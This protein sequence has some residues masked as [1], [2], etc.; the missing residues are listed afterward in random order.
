MRHHDDPADDIRHLDPID[1][2]R[3]AATW[4]DGDAKKALFQE[5]ITMP[6]DPATS[7]RL[8]APVPARTLRR[9]VAFAV[10]LAVAVA[11]LVVIQGTLFKGAPAYAVRPLPNGVIEIS[12]ATDLRDGNAIAAELREYGVDVAITTVPG[13]PSAVGELT[14]IAPGGGDY[15]PEG[16]SYAGP[17]GTPGVFTWLIDP[18]VFH[19][20][21]TLQITVAA[22]AG[23]PY[24]IAE[25]VFEPGEVLGGLQCALG[26]PVRAEDVASR[27]GD[28]G[29]TPMWFVISP[30]DDPWTTYS[31]QVEDVPNGEILS[32]YAVDDTTVRFTVVPDGVTLSPEFGPARLSDVPCTPEQAAA[33][34]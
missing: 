16:L 20:R 18:E 13:S 7:T 30:T 10:G 31:E 12:F 4:S 1:G 26:E 22:R 33:W 24:V 14:A 8:P 23:E 11:A 27:L 28:L 6:V 17:D 32:G 21:I 2:E 5:I 29:I 34:N 25:E 3:L 9:R 15:I 19:E